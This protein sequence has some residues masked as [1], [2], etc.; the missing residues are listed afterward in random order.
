MIPPPVVSSNASRWSI[1]SF[2]SHRAIR[3]EAHAHDA[4]NSGPFAGATLLGQWPSPQDY[5]HKPLL[6]VPLHEAEHA[7]GDRDFDRPMARIQPL[8]RSA[9]GNSIAG[10][11]P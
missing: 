6:D 8:V 5:S 7:P 1:A 11:G 3:Q 2:W 9:S 10:Y 4:R